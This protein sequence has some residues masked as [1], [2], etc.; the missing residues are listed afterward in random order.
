MQASNKESY[1]ERL[2][3]FSSKNTARS[4]AEKIGSVFTEPLDIANANSRVMQNRTGCSEQ[5]AEFIRLVASINSRRLTDEFKIGRK[6]TKSEIE[7]YIC[8]LLFHL[9]VESVYMISFD[10]NGKLLSCDLITEGTVNSSAFLPRKMADIAL[11]KRAASIIL[12]HNHPSGNPFPSNNDI[13]VTL[14][15]ESVLKDAHIRLDAHYITVGFNIYDCLK[16]IKE[17]S[18]AKTEI[19][20]I[21]PV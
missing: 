11:S 18:K 16:E 2:L 6:Y 8:A 19:V 14:L 7:R 9:T 1:L 3:C 5:T 10:K 20:K 12:A 17:S 13:A 21:N 4:E 15:A